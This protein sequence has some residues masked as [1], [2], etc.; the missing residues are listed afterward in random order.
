MISATKALRSKLEFPVDKLRAIPKIGPISGATSMAPITT[1]TLFDKSPKA[2]I[3]V[4]RQ[5]IKWNDGDGEDRS[6]IF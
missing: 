4:E 2:A 1:A 6:V 3:I 5:T